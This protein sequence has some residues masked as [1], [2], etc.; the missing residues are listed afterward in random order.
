MWGFT[1][2]EVKPYLDEKIR[3]VIFREGVIG[4]LGIKTEQDT[5]DA[6]CRA[7]K[8]SGK[9]LDCESCDKKIEVIGEKESKTI[10]R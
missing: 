1:L 10:G 3:W 4:F 8:A 7:C 6:Y 9:E 2:D 5:S